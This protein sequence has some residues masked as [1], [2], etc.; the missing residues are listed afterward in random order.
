VVT[1]YKTGK[2]PGPQYEQRRL[3]G[4]HFYAF[5]CEQLLGRRPAAVRLMYLASGETITAY[6]SEQ[7][8]RFLQQRTSAVHR[9]IT[10]AC[11]QGG[12]RPRPGPLCGS[13]AFRQWCPAF[14]GDPELAAVEAPVRY[15]PTAA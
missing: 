10:R 3:G 12:F 6:P 7:S 14:G 5:L 8:I 2:A 1:D 4:V 9:A 15:A 11:E 13:C